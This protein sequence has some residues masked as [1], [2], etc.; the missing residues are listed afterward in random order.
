MVIFREFVGPV[1]AGGL[2]DQFNDFKVVS[3]IYSAM[4]YIVVSEA[5]WHHMSYV[6]MMF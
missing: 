2:M 3:S 6:I 4:L 5:F 1:L